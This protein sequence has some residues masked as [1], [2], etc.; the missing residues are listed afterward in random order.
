MNSSKQMLL[1]G[2]RTKRNSRD[3][4]ALLG[5]APVLWNNLPPVAVKDRIRASQLDLLYLLFKGFIVFYYLF[6]LFSSF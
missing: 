5:S 2:P 6:L 3:Y 4:G 1:D